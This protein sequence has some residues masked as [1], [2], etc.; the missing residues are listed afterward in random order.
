[1][2]RRFTTLQ[3]WLSTAARVFLAVVFFA[4]GWPKFTDRA[5]TV[6]SVRA[7]KLVPEAIVHPF[8]YAL[9]TI[10]LLLA[11][12]LLLGLLTRFASV[13]IAGLLLMFMFGI[14]MA[15]SRGLSLDCGCFGHTGAT[16]VDA[17]PG[18]IK[19]LFRD[20][21]FLLAAVF[22]VRWPV[23]RFSL[24]GLLGLNALP[25]LDEDFDEL[26]DDELEDDEPADESETTAEPS[27]RVATP[28]GTSPA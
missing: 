11:L 16:V 1:M 24:D 22:L 5:G 26:E 27:A 25:A 13:A 10:E 15:W 7:F 23:S 3:P 4:A 9:P 21:G 20:T 28:E 18:Y 14:V 2:P 12:A 17:V 19:D 6:R 8:A